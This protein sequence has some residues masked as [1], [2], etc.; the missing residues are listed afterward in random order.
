LTILE[1]QRLVYIQMR[2]LGYERFEE[3]GVFLRNS[4]E[5][6]EEF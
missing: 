3:L 4:D 1:E 6:F 5:V 2:N